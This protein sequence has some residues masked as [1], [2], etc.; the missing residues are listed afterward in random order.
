MAENG[1][2][3]VI[4]EPS[5]A[6]NDELNDWYARE[7]LPERLAIEGFLTA[8][9]F[10]STTRPR[11][12]LALYDLT[13]AA[14]LHTD[15]YEAHA[16]ENNSAWTKRVTS[17]VRFIRHEATQ[18][19]PGRAVTTPAPCQLVVQLSGIGAGRVD[20]LTARLKERLGGLG[21]VRQARIFL[22][23]ADSVGTMFVLVESLSSVSSGLDEVLGDAAGKATLV[24]EFAPF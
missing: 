1:L 18:R 5:E 21:G 6:M 17:R 16:G 9:R 11:R 3:F 7:H 10:V 19:H 24:E 14:V 22:G 20:E 12:Y 13:G 2:L 23:T 8:I 15:A 4:S